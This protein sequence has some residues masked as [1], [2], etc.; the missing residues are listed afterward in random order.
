MKK[1]LTLTLASLFASSAFAEAPATFKMAV[2]QG[3]NGA[4]D[5]RKGNYEKGIDSIV[6]DTKAMEANEQLAMQMNLCV[7]YANSSQF[8]LANKACDQAITLSKTFVE[9]DNTATKFVAFALNNRAI[10]K[11]KI[12]DFDGALQDLMEA[13]QVNNTSIV[14]DNLL[15]L[16]H[17]QADNIQFKTVQ[18]TQA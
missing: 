12:Q 17:Q 5:I 8:A 11:T 2:V 1:L 9:L 14:E 7:A 13:A 18:V 3:T 15:K 16:I 10:Y 6:T 4:S